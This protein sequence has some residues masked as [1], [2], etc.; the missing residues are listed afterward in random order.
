MFVFKR[1]SLL[2]LV[3]AFLFTLPV[4]G[5]KT[6]SHGP[7]SI[8]LLQGEEIT[9]YNHDSI[10]YLR[11]HPEKGKYFLDQ[12]PVFLIDYHNSDF[13]I[14]AVDSVLID[15]AGYAFK[16]YRLQPFLLSGVGGGN[17]TIKVIPYKNGDQI[18]FPHSGGKIRIKAIENTPFF[19]NDAIVLGLLLLVLA[20]IFKTSSMD[21]F[22][23]FYKYVPALLL[24][25][26]IPSL[27]N[28]SGLISGDY[29]ELYYVASRYLLPASL[30][31]LCLSIDLKGIRSL[32]SKAIWMFLAATV[33]IIVGGPVAVMLCKGIFPDLASGKGP[34]E[35]YRGLST[36]AG[37]WI[38]GGANQTAMKEIYEPSAGLFSKMIV[39]DVVVANIW[40]AFLLFGSG[41]TQQLDRWLKADSSAIDALKSKLENYSDS[42]KRIPSFTDLMVIVG[43][44][45]V[46]V[47]A[48]HW[49]A[50]LIS[51][52]LGSFEESLKSVRLGSLLKPFF[53]LVVIATTIGVLLSF[54]KMRSYEGAGASKIGSLFLYILVATIGMHM[55][56]LKIFESPELF[57]VGLVWMLVH[58]L[59][60][61]LVAKLIKAPFFF[62]AVGSQA[63]VGGAASAPVVASAFSP[64]LAPVG[65]LL[66]VFGYAL[67]TYGAIICT[68]IMLRL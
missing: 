8:S 18:A 43:V 53:W 63:N 17:V 42:I 22:A 16:T 2:F 59:I 26:F 10:Q 68:E 61:L 21:R 32:G 35:L 66:A 56:V 34:D 19:K 55:D 65:V 7:Y 6:M 9:N 41:I 23:G 24:C 52:G 13:Q 50:D 44:G 11:F 38:G 54:S 3:V 60:L 37:S 67:G 58:V 33:G 39:V 48:A 20:L 57:V 12:T 14:G 1:L 5:L 15:I 36:V 46:G 28:S 31:L 4:W 27:L 64:A 29:S 47:A 51:G 45:M 30:V 25:Y 49:G 40:M 62:V